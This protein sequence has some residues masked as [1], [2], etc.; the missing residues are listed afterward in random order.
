MLHKDF[1]LKE[2]SIPDHQPHRLIELA[3]KQKPSNI[4]LSISALQEKIDQ[5]RIKD[6]SLIEW[7]WCIDNDQIWEAIPEEE[8]KQLTLRIWRISQENKWLYFTLIR[9][10]AWFYHGQ[11]NVITS[12]LV[13]GFLLWSNSISVK[14]NLVIKILVALG[15]NEPKKAMVK[16]IC[17]QNLTHNELLPKINH[18]LPNLTI[19]KDY[20]LEIAPYFT[21]QLHPVT[22]D[23][24]NWLLRCFEQMEETDQIKSVEYI[25]NHLSTSIVGRYPELVNWLK[26][27]YHNSS[28]QS[29]LSSQARQ[30][31]RIWIGAVNYQD[32]SNLVDLIAQRIGITDK[33][34]NQLNKRQGFWANYSNSFMRI[35]ILLPM[36]SY[37]I[38]NHDLR[39]DQDVQRLRSDGS[40]ETEICIFDLGENG[41][42]VEF[43]RGRGSET[44]IF[45]QNDYIESVLFGS[46]PLS[47]K[48]IR[49][50]GGEAHD[51]A[52]A[53]QWSCEQLLRTKY[54]ILPNTGTTSFIG[55]PPKYGRYDTS[56][57]LPNPDDQ[58][59][60]ERQNQ[61]QKWNRIINQLE[62]EAK[63][64]SY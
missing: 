60:N 2:F 14:D 38:I 15:A 30:K 17:D 49:K 32:F 10:L 20:V 48:R 54:Q 25:L 28:K 24:V 19:F 51:H 57:G 8:R 62:L 37:E 58:K 9:R 46:Q 44:R 45:P 6:I 16:I 36:Q 11:K 4:N 43:F 52:L 18:V 1:N 3:A 64:S 55:L 31:L 29:K 5:N 40:D 21:K 61:L 22:L 59:L 56:L 35:K 23:K 47:V 39:A 53:W 27:N 7:I 34:E 41:F 12:H 13:N 50:L 42:I 33:E 26:T 63:R